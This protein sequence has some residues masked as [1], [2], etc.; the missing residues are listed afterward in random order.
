MGNEPLPVL[1]TT[2]FFSTL[3]FADIILLSSR[4]EKMLST[5]FQ[6][7]EVYN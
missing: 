7:W 1:E 4:V 3:F 5:Y 6:D 2:V